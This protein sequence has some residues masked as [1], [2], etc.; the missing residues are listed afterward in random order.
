MIV[1]KC[2]AST[3]STKALIC[4]D[5]DE[6]YFPHACE[7]GQLRILHAMELYLNRIPAASL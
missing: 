6:T 3:D 5:F 2:F 1:K 4:F 7:K